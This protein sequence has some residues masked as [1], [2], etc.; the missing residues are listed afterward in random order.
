M[1]FKLLPP[2]RVPRAAVT[3]LRAAFMIV[4][5]VTVAVFVVVVIA[6]VIVAVVV[7]HLVVI[8]IFSFINNEDTLMILDDV[9]R[10]ISVFNLV[11]KH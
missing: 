1:S 10:M 5:V 11:K 6:V 7:I 2:F 4:A 8:Y 3:T 9:G